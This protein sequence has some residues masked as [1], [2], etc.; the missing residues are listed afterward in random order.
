MENFINGYPGSESQ[1][2]AAMLKVMGQEN[3]DFFFDCFHDYFFTEKDAMLIKSLGLNCARIPFSYKH[4][5][6]DMNPRVLKEKGFERLDR[7][8]DLCTSHGIFVILD[9]HTVPGCQN[10]DQHSDNHTS[11]SAFWD[12]KDHQDRTIWLW[13]KIAE[14]YKDNTLIAGYNPM[15]EPC[16]PEQFRVSVFY[17]R[18]EKAVRAIDP[19]HI[20]FLDGNT[21]AME[22]KGFDKILPNAVYSIHDY[23]MM[24][25][26]IGQRYKGTQAQDDKLVQQ[27]HRKCEFHH[28]NGVPI[29]VGEFGPTFETRDSDKETINQERFNLLGRQL[30]IYEENNVSWSMWNYKDM[31]HMG[32]VSTSLESPYHKMLQPFLD[33]KVFLQIDN[34]SIQKSNEVDPLIDPFVEWIDRVSPAAKKTYPPNWDTNT[35]VRRNLL[36]T[37]LA[38]SFTEEFAEHFRGL[39][40]PQLDELAR[41]WEL[42]QC[43]Q[44]VGLNDV[45]VKTTKG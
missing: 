5:E 2:R 22:W 27:Y 35:H 9:M 19:H 41:S 14:R 29:W 1:V 20:L 15:N 4:F 39:D 28:Q 40:K 10:P 31:G 37:L 30:S 21:F 11:Y 25:F 36:H 18:L 17:E 34:A 6:D 3:Y 45:V 12:F 7:M 24:G 13:E 8:V 42:D 26:P 23:S 33:K 38:A 32:M 44:K 43:V 16:D